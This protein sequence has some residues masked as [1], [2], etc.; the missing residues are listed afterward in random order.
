M[1]SGGQQRAHSW[2]NLQPTPETPEEARV[3]ALLDGM[4]TTSDG[5]KRLTMW[6]ELQTI[7][8]EQS[9]VIWLPVQAIKSPYATASATCARPH[10]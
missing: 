6:R 7:A 3:D 2:S 9:W 4:T 10:S 1:F 5:P 8:N